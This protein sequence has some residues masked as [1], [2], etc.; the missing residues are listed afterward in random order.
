ML[1]KLYWQSILAPNPDTH[2]VF[3][4]VLDLYKAN[5]IFIFGALV[6]FDSHST[7]CQKSNGK[8]QENGNGEVE[9]DDDEEDIDEKIGDEEDNDLDLSWKMLDIARTI[10]EKS[11]EN[12]IEKVKK[13]SGL[14][15]VATERDN[16]LTDYMRA[17]SM[18]EHLVEP[19]HRR[20]VELNFRICLVYEL[21]SKIGD[22]IPYC[23]KAISLCKSHGNDAPAVEA[24][25]G[26][27]KTAAEK[28]LEQLTSI[29]N[30][31]MLH[32]SLEDLDQAAPS[33]AMD[34]MVKTI[35]SR[36]TDAMPGAASFTCSQMAA[37]SNGFNSSRLCLPQRQPE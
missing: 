23:T 17:L 8:Y 25:G 32:G 11:Q 16:S 34:E 19:D 24:E 7:S 27:E 3:Y 26:S 15:E 1:K 21:V 28:E 37:S 35:A 4:F 9:K 30:F 6:S 13:Y 22:A 14:A 20:V 5:R 18:L 12:T 31:I 29:C 36:I 33:P 10:V 2:N